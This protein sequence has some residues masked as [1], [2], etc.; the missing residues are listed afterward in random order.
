MTWKTCS[1]LLVTLCAALDGCRTAPPDAP[2]PNAI[3][4]HQVTIYEYKFVPPRLV[5]PLGTQ[6]T[7]LN[8]DYVRHTAT[9]VA[10]VEPFDSRDIYMQ[11]RYSHTFTTLGEYHYLCVP[12]PGMKGVIVVE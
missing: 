12:H 7:W 11:S 10:S 2:A 5:V 4:P 6:V 8:L 3:D 9:S 1:L